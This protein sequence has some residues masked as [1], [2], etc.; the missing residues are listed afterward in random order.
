M[1]SEGKVEKEKIEFK[2]STAA[3]VDKKS[4]QGACKEYSVKKLLTLATSNIT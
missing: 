1:E 2:N 4:G 3:W